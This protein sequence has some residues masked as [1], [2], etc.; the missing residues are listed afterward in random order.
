M[1]LKRSLTACLFFIIWPFLIYAQGTPPA[2][3][4]VETYPAGAEVTLKGE[5]VVIGITPTIFRQSLIGEYKVDIKKYGYEKYTTRVALDPGKPQQLSVTLTPKSRFKAAVRSM[6]I[7]GWGQMYS[8]QK[9][10]SMVYN[11]LAVGSVAAFLLADHEYNKEYDDLTACERAYDSTIANGGSYNELERRYLNLRMA[12]EDAYDAE[13]IRR[14]SI[15]AVI[16][17]WTVNILDALFF[18]PRESG[19]FTV[20]GLTVKPEADGY[21]VGFT[22]TKNF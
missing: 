4:T 16:G 6:I 20:K 9:T 8:E 12:R 14:I 21:K 15:G 11:L 13:T 3:F 22:L 19:T 5:A 7:P 17:V 10:K 1:L 2:G 18:F